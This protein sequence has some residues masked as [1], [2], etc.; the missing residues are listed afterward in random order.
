MQFVENSEKKMRDLKDFPKALWEIMEALNTS[1]LTTIT[2]IQSME[3]YPCNTFNMLPPQW[4][5]RIT[6]YKDGTHGKH[7]FS[8]HHMPNTVF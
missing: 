3:W 4:A 1:I 6:D 8:S 5:R 7:A 2:L